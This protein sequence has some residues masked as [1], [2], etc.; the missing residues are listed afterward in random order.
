[1]DQ[2]V[3]ALGRKAES[4]PRERRLVVPLPQEVGEDKRGE[5]GV[6]ERDGTQQDAD[7]NNNFGVGDN[8][9]GGVI[10]GWE[11]D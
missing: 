1:M 8:L 3:H 9:H 4:F 5:Q 11:S 7:E 2:R 6:L 10:V